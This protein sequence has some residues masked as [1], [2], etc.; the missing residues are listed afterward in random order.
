MELRFTEVKKL[1]EFH[2]NGLLAFTQTL[3]YLHPQYA[4]LYDRRI[5]EAGKQFIRRDKMAK[6]DKEGKLV[7]E[8]YYDD[9]GNVIKNK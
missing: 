1:D 5:G 7:W 9:S 6:Y 4:H 3:A 2:T 8:L